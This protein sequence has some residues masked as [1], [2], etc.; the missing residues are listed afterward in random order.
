VRQGCG[1]SVEIKSLSNFA[2]R[3]KACKCDSSSS[4]QPCSMP[5]ISRPPGAAGLGNLSRHIASRLSGH[6]LHR[7]RG[8]RDHGPIIS[9]LLCARA[10]RGLK[11]DRIGYPSGVPAGSL[12]SFLPVGLCV[13][14]SVPIVSAL[15]R[16]SIPVSFEAG[17]GL[18]L[19]VELV[20]PMP[21]NPCLLEKQRAA[22]GAVRLRANHLGV[23]AERGMQHVF[24]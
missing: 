24:R 6:R 4:R 16:F 17:L 1:I 9:G 7:G 14:V 3:L 2:H 23:V 12:Q 13:D 18:G 21:S 5:R 10:R 22:A 19:C 8:S 15:P 11:P 20:L